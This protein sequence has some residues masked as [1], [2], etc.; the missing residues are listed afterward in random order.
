MSKKTYKP[1]RF[2]EEPVEPIFHQR[3]LLEKKPVCPDGFQW[4]DET[5]TIVELLMEWHDY[6][7]K[8]RSARNM[9]SQHA[10][11]AR[12]RGSWGVGKFYFRVRTST[13]RI[14]DIYYDRSPKDVD[15]R[16][17]SWFLN[18]ELAVD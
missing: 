17:G 4:A 18:Q 14:F 15:H 5:F 1:V 11:I 9:Q 8:G 7:R 2:I 13:D 3:N 10:A 12:V 16:K 6:Q